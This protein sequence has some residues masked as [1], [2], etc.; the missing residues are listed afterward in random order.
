MYGNKISPGI[1]GASAALLNAPLDLIALRV[2][3]SWAD[4]QAPENRY[5]GGYQHGMMQ[6]YE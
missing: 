4:R 5:V 2:R 6:R 3:M 1:N